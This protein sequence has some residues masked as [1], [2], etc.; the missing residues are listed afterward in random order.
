VRLAALLCLAALPAAAAP[1][2]GARPRVALALSGGGARGIAHI[3]VLEA[4]EENGIPVDAIAGTS[5]GALVGA[6][7][8]SGRPAGDLE[9]VVSSL[10]WAAIFG[11]RP[12][13]RLLPLLRRPECF[14]TFAGVGFESFKLRLP[15]GALPEYG[16]NRFLIENLAEAG[17]AAK[18]DFDRLPIP[19]RAVAAALDNRERIV[20]SRGSLPRAVRASLSIPV[21]FAPVDWNGRALV[22]GGVVDNLPVREARALG[23]AVVVAVDIS[24]P[25]L[26]RERYRDVIG[27]AAQMS[28]LLTDRANEDYRAQADVLVKPDLGQHSFG[29]YTDLDELIALGYEAA[30]GAVPEIRRRLSEVKGDLGPRA[31]PAPGPSLSGRPIA[32][33]VVEGQRRVTERV[34]RRVFNVPLHVPF[35]VKKGLRAL[36]KLHATGLF[37][38][39]FL[40]FEEAGA[41]LRIVLRVREAPL[42]RAEVGASYDEAARTR[43]VVKLRQRNALGSGEEAEATL[44][45]GDAGAGIRA[46]LQ[47]ERL[48]T[49]ALGFSLVLEAETERPRFFVEGDSPNRARFTRR[50]MA[51]GVHRSLERWGLVEAGLHVGS[52][53]TSLRSGLPFEAGTDAIASAW[54]TFAVDTRDDADLPEAGLLVSARL[55]QS[56]TGLGA[57][58]DYGRVTGRGQIAGRLGARGAFEANAFLGL[59]AGEVPPYDLFRIGGP[60]L[61]PGRE[62]DELW[63]AR[64][65]AASLALRL[66]LVGPLRLVG[67]VGAGQV[68]A[69][70][71]AFRLGDVAIGVGLGLVYPTRMGPVRLDLGRRQGGETLVTFAI[72]AH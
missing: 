26:P 3:G 32:E 7:F 10:D 40:D 45:V 63:G 49:P 44:W 68:F 57:D 29:D 60:D 46:A 67:R 66:R 17:F 20:L 15:A 50:G 9:T 27:V 14:R 39:C 53:K 5:M 72:G 64:A 28:G 4:F 13:R 36:D 12:D 6:L 1:P 34:I 23:A 8:A 41:G 33:V 47:G 61:V 21:A 48:F 62:I 43:G 58:L 65:I 59:S 16:V 30:V 2:D 31:R 52:V 35:D 56:L 69:P 38:H 55:D 11:G 22:D 19:F 25:P 71:T 18:G 54:G 70:E 37:E 51:F 24:S 42:T